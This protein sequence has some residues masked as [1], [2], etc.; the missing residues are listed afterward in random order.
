MEKSELIKF[1][2]KLKEEQ[3]EIE[4]MINNLHH[5]FERTDVLAEDE[6]ADMY[7]ET[8]LEE[9]LEDILKKRLQI[10]NIALRKIDQGTYGICEKCHQPIEK[11]KLEIDPASIYCSLCS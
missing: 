7:E 5:S 3:Q 11:E 9:S 4:K 10:I 8:E 1:E 6:V 2:K